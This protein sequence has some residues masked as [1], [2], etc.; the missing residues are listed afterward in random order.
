M[1]NSALSPF[2]FGLVMNRLTVEDRQESLFR[3]FSD[4]ENRKQVEEN[5]ERW[6]YAPEI[7]GLKVISIFA[8]LL[9]IFVKTETLLVD[10]SCR[11]KPRAKDSVKHFQVMRRDNAYIFGFNEFSSFQDFI[12]H[13]ANQPLLG[14]DTGKLTCLHKKTNYFYF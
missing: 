1:L 5:L 9:D 4:D 14:S 13:F 10:F 3:M 2:L 8:L 12:N 11:L 7:R 6:R